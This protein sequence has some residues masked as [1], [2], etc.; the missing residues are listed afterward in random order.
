LR[1]NKKFSQPSV[2][3]KAGLR[4]KIYINNNLCGYYK[5]LWGRVKHLHQKNAIKEF[6]VFNGTL[7]IRDDS[8]NGS[9]RITHLNDLIDLFPDHENIL[10]N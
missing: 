6:W 10:L 4:E 1:N 5:F 2:Q 9:H 3:E 7:N 8:N